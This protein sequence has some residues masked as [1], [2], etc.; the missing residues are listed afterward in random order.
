MTEHQS[1]RKLA[2][3]SSYPD[4]DVGVSPGA[5]PG[6]GGAPGETLCCDW[7][8]ATTTLIAEEDTD[9][10]RQYTS[11]TRI[12]FQASPPDS[13]T[14]VHPVTDAEQRRTAPAEGRPGAA[15]SRAG[16]ATKPVTYS[17]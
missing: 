11:R 8:E 17:Y 5:P 2:T 9:K 3:Q 12:G 10:T 1:G 7:P 15:G 6:F 16:R 13:L 14:R 4:W